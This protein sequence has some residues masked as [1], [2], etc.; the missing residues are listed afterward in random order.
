MPTRLFYLCNLRIGTYFLCK[1]WQAIPTKDRVALALD[2]HPQV[3]L[4]DDVRAVAKP[5]ETD[6]PMLACPPTPEPE[7]M[8]VSMVA[9]PPTPPKKGKPSG[10]RV[11]EKQ[12]LISDPPKLPDAALKLAKQQAQEVAT[13]GKIE[14]S[15]DEQRELKKQK[16]VQAR[17]LAE[18]KKQNALDKKKD[19]AAKALEK[20]E[21]KLKAAQE[22]AE[23]ISTG[24]RK[25]VKR[26][27][28]KE[29]NLACEAGAS[30][31]PS[32]PRAYDSKTSRRRPSKHVKLSPKAKK[33]AAAT[34]P[35]KVATAS[36][37]KA[38]VA[39]KLL[40]DTKLP[41]LSLPGE[42]FSKKILGSI[43]PLTHA[44]YMFQLWK[45]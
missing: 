19:A 25:P 15:T 27:L 22:K 17:E 11:E 41:Y 14:L 18:K 39:L 34:S 37:N 9:C 31:P 12:V 10:S 21:Q 29:L 3:R 40:R 44:V 4:L 32:S 33:F 16:E 23:Q 20:A 1:L 8:D 28:E 5:D 35:S 13:E 2:D 38:V 24:A 45:L 42:N 7:D 6:S 36:Q 43:T 30:A 26:K